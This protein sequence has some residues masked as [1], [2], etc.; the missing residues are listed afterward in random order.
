[1]LSR[2]GVIVLASSAAFAGTPVT[3]VPP[4]TPAPA[5]VGATEARTITAPAGFIDDAIA[6]DATRLAYVVADGQTK[7]ELHVITGATETVT[8]LAPLTLHPIAIELLG[9]RAFVTGVDANSEQVGGLVELAK[10]A[11]KPILYRVGPAQH[12]TLVKRD[13]AK[14]I[15]L[16]RLEGTR[17]EIELVSLE[18]GKRIAAR[19]FELDA[20][21]T[22][23]ALD[24]HVNHWSEGWTRAHGLKGGEWDPKENMRMPAVEATYD[25]VT[26]KIIERH[27][28][29]D[30]FEQRK[31]YQV[32]ADAK[33]SVG[34]S[35][36]FV[37]YSWD[38]SRIVAWR[39]G[40]ATPIELDQPLAQYDPKSL[41]GSIE[42]DGSTWIAL[43]VDPVNPEAVA[44]QKA[45]PEYFDLF[46]AGADGKAVR[47]M[48]VLA[49]EKRFR[50][51]VMRDRIWLLER[52]NGFDRGGTALRIYTLN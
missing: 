27:P 49:S 10:D 8:D 43:K 29:T 18:T 25:V 37:R 7:S 51:G 47:K 5:L 35:I 17:H 19:G 1:M 30:L 38:N 33:S 32:L 44:R 9:S 12:L 13:G 15:A 26:G 48:R 11:K 24:F 34:S 3:P 23:K 50:F 52:S 46:K 14:R 22:N 4:R 2:V 39:A 41:Q 28:I 40:K 6:F 20:A 42:A 31:R 36:D 21:D 16:H 45:D